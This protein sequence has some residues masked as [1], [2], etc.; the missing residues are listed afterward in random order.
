[1][2]RLKLGKDAPK[3]N[4]KTMLFSRYVNAAAPPPPPEKTYYEYKIPPETIGMYGNDLVGDCVV[5][6]MFHWLMLI[7]AHAG[8]IVIPGPDD[9]KKVYSDITG[10]NEATGEN[11][12]GMAVTDGLNYWQTVGLCGHKI[13]GWAQLDNKNM[14]RRNQGLYTFFGVGVGIQCPQSAQDQFNA[15]QTWTYVPN[16]P[17]EGGH[18]ILE[19]GYGKDGR[20]FESWG[21]G[22]VKGDN[23]FDQQ[24][25]DETYIVLTKDLIEEASDLSPTG[26]NWDALVAD[27]AALKA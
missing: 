14:L 9:W 1:M 10:W 13:D 17:I 4:E 19:S 27:L 22:D 8:K 15:G 24:Y 21:K 11:D 6:G 20:N 5:A 18:F 23:G 2:T 25:T 7:T 3:F 16:S 12:N 26:M